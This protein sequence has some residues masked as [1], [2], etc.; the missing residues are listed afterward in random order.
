MSRLLII[1]S[2]LLAVTWSVRII[3]LSH[4][5]GPDTLMFADSPNFRRSD[6]F[7][8]DLL[9][10][11]FVT[12]GKYSS[13]EHGGT[14]MDAPNNIIKDGRSI[15]DIPLEDTIAEGVQIDCS[16]EAARDRS[17]LVPVQ[18]ILDWE[19]AYGR[20]P[21]G[22]AVIM[23]FNWSSKINNRTLYLGNESD[24]IF[25]YVF[26]AVS[27][28][29]ADWLYTNR[30]IKMIGTDTYTPDPLSVN[31]V[32]VTSFPV[33]QILLSNNSL[34]VENLKGTERLP[35]TGFMFHAPPVKYAGN[36]GAQ[37]RAYAV[38]YEACNTTKPGS[39]Y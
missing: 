17:F 34:I 9:P 4:K 31:G 27:A 13:G 7:R 16:Q 26:P 38:I 15:S 8:G 21:N 11:V 35:P 6:I 33:H 32:K 14:H 36:T 1:L 18:K 29:A 24:D 20:I 2:A 10:G 39:G 30:H 19:K 25:S 37:V 28:E 12:Y 23:N 22:A 3:D 5:H